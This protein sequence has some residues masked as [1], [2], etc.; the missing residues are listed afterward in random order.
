MRCV[1]I[2][3]IVAFIFLSIGD[4]ATACG[5]KFLVVG[6][7]LRYD[8]AYPAKH[9]SSVVIYLEDQKVG[10]QLEGMLK[11]SGH[12]VQSVTDEAGLFSILQSSKSD[13][14]LIDLS[15][16]AA[17]QNRIQLAAGE[18]AVLPVTVKMS[19]QDAKKE[20][21]IL[22]ISGKNRHPVAMIDQVMEARIKGLPQICKTK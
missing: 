10:R 7:A 20:Q 8:R 16:A 18:P 6:R 19:K 21:C 14:V 12:K 13:V 17:L 5:D 3:W 2:I 22:N 15:K 4:Q 11:S 9:P 1:N